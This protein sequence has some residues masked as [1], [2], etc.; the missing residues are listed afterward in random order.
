MGIRVTT[1]CTENGK[2]EPV[3]HVAPNM[4]GPV[5]EGTNYDAGRS[6]CGSLQAYGLAFLGR[7]IDIALDGVL[8]KIKF[9]LVSGEPLILSE[10]FGGIYKGIL[11]KC[12]ELPLDS[13]FSLTAPKSV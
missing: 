9:T 3:L 1:Q 6:I 12:V 5:S 7:R 2:I 11:K 10:G 13:T 8:K 4:V